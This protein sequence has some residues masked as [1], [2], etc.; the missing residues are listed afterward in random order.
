[1]NRTGISELEI[2]LAVARRGSFS[3][4]ASELEISPSAVTNAVAGLEKRLGVRLFNRTT[5]SVGLTEAG[6]RFMVKIAP[7]V[8]MI[9]SASAE[10]ASLP[11]DPAGSLRINVPPESCA[12]WYDEILLPFLARYPRI[13]ADIH[14]QKDKVDIVAAGYDAGIRLEDDIPADMIPVKLTPPLRMIL[15]ASPDYLSRAGTPQQPEQ[16]SEHCCIC[17]RMADGSIYRWELSHQQQNYKVQVE[18]LLTVNDLASAQ[19][20]VVGGLGIACMSE[21][22]IAADVQAGRVIQLMPEWQVNLGAL[23]LYYPGH[24]LVPPTLKALT[25]FIREVMTT[26]D[27]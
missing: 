21:R 6:R 9:R 15:V 22:H 11:A 13:R 24:R 14:S 7:A 12:L 27:L 4:A 17:M 19:K 20:A 18:P 5:R 8:E 23:C 2:M 26:T 16:L 10:V 25:E 3:G 1:M